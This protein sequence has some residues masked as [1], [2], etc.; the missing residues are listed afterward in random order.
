MSDINLPGFLDMTPEAAAHELR[1]MTTREREE[2]VAG[3]QAL[4]R[5]MSQGDV[6]EAAGYMELRSRAVELATPVWTACADQPLAEI[7]FGME[8]YLVEGTW[9]EAV[10]SLK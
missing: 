7:V 1:M 8:Q 3:L 6:S 4:L 9:P 5:Q 2:F 10:G